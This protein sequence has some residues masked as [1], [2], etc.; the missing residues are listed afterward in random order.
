MEAVLDALGDLDLAFAGEQLDG[1]HLAHVH[2]HQV[3]VLLNP[4]IH[5]RQGLFGLLDVFSLTDAATPSF[6]SRSSAD[7]ASSDLDVHAVEGGDDRLDLLGVDDII[8]RVTFD[9]RVGEVAR[10]LPRVISV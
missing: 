2:A 3:G 4:G 6:I 8:R 5:R 1:T 7:G 9:L 10:S